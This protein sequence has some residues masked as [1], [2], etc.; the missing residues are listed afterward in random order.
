MIDQVKGRINNSPSFGM[1]A[2]ATK[3]VATRVKWAQA[4]LANTETQK[5]LEE[6]T[7]GYSVFFT[8]PKERQ[9]VVA[10]AFK[11]K[12]KSKTINKIVNWFF[13]KFPELKIKLN[14][15]PQDIGYGLAGSAHQGQEISDKSLVKLAT[16]S[17]ENYE[18]KASAPKLSKAE[19]KRI[20]KIEW[21]EIERKVAEKKKLVVA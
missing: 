7:P 5:L 3:R 20:E 14:N 16:K 11:D 6:K 13:K 10:W 12:S 1:S 4:Q 19:Q 21:L 8:K 17:I 15:N 18:K 9:E 2:T